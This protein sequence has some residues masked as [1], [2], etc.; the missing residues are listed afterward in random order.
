MGAAASSDLTWSALQSWPEDG[1]R[2]ELLGGELVV[3]PAPSP[4][5]QR[6][7]VQLIY[8]L[9]V[10]ADEHGGEVLPGPIDVYVHEREY[11]EPDVVYLRPDRAGLIEER[12]ISVPPDLLV[13]VSSPSTRERDLGVKRDVYERFG[14]PEYWFVDLDERRVLVHRLT[15]GRYEVEERRPGDSLEP[16]CCPGL[17]I[18][19]AQ[20]L[21]S[22]S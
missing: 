20:L 3:T 11:T 8:A 13:E 6:V 5:H 18:P 19:V 17:H 12:R 15:G 22:A 21:G 10:W 1:R 4:G 9:K 16:H 2:Y 14:V 7:V